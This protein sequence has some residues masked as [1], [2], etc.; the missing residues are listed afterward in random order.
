MPD[1]VDRYLQEVGALLRVH[2]RRRE[3]V[4]EE[5]DAHL[6]ESAERHG[7]AR[8]IA[9]MGEPAAVAQGFT[10][11][12]RD[13]LWEERDRL[14]ALT[15]LLAMIMALPMAADLIALNG[16]VG[17]STRWAALVL[18]PSALLAAA[19]CVLVLARRPVG[20]R[21]AAPLA[22]LVAVTA[23]VTLAGLGPMGGLLNGYEQG[24]RHGYEANGCAGRTLAA[25]ASDHT[26]EARLNFSLGAVAL[27]LAYLAAVTGWTPRRPGGRRARVA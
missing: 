4:L 10:P 13:R 8:A 20:V 15:M 24:I 7:E 12:L 25:C 27:S 14:A 11:R 21:L 6:R 3:R 19:S 2:P 26:S 9:R 18:A 23:V 1:P 16:K 5:L 17:S 22:V